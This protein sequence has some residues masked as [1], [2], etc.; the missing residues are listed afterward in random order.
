MT[1]IMPPTK[2]RTVQTATASKKRKLDEA[3]EK[4]SGPPPLIMRKL[5]KNFR[6]LGF[7]AKPLNPSVD[8]FW[9]YGG[10]LTKISRPELMTLR[11][12]ESCASA[13]CGQV[14]F[15]AEDRIEV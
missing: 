5:Q 15:F 14:P 10:K 2:Q 9:D 1:G 8:I 7:E 11:L 4:H 3:M 13:G 6:F 12:N